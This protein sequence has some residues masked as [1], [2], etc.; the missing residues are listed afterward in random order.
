MSA[1]F[2]RPGISPELR[3]ALIDPRNNYAFDLIEF[4][5][6][7][8]GY[9]PSVHYTPTAFSDRG[10]A[11]H[12]F[13]RG[14]RGYRHQIVFGYDLLVDCYQGKFLTIEYSTIQPVWR[15][16]GRREFPGF[17]GVWAVALH[18]F[19]HVLQCDTPAGRTYGSV[20][21]DVFIAKLQY[22]IA[23]FPF[24][25]ISVRPRPMLK[26]KVLER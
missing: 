10:G 2:F 17:V 13:L 22:L 14:P 18:E 6:A 26:K 21:N 24:E 8:H 20:H 25:T 4:L 3:R 9:V 15:K 11:A 23:N 5:Y 1:S 7:Q 16:A 19:A 12:Q